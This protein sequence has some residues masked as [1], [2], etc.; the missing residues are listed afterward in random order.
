MV[1]VRRVLRLR[2]T[3]DTHQS[4]P[5]MKIQ[6][7]WPPFSSEYIHIPSHLDSIDCTS[8]AQMYLDAPYLVAFFIFLVASQEVAGVC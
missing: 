5:S 6:M 2:W 4:F 7:M 1:S 3:M 8:D